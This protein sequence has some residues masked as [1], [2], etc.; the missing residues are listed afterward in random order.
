MGAHGHM[1]LSINIKIDCCLYQFQMDQDSGDSGVEIGLY[2]RR[3]VDK[4]I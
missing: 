3:R 1:F 4:L 2:L